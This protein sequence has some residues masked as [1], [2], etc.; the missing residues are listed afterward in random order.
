[1]A[2]SGLEMHHQR[3]IASHQPQRWRRRPATTRVI[4]VRVWRPSSDHRVAERAVH[5]EQLEQLNASACRESTRTVRFSPEVSARQFECFAVIARV[6][7]VT[8]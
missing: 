8:K 6:K 4:D 5:Q 1:M 3:H 7:C 2:F